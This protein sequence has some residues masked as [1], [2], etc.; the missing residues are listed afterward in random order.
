MG[1]I[2]IN[3]IAKDTTT[4]TQY[5]YSD[6]H[7]D[8]ANDYKIR[9][10]FPKDETSV[11]DIKVAHDM[12]AI[13]N[14]LGALFS[15]FPG[16]RLLL[17]EFGLNIKRFLFSPISNGNAMAIGEMMKSAVSNWEP[18]VEIMDIAIAPLVDEQVYNID[19]EFFVPSL[20]AAGHFTGNV[21]HGDGFIQ[22]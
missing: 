9:A 1:S 10:N 20:K 16:Q 21:I 11:I 22:G 15:T 19:I 6:V 12:E 2:N 5:L 8:L 18:R 17:P 7:L 13:K 14:S 3:Y 4:Q